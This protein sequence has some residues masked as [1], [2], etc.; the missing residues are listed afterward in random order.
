MYVIVSG[1]MEYPGRFSL[2]Q[3]VGSHNSKLQGKGRMGQVHFHKDFSDPP[4]KEGTKLS[5]PSPCNF[6]LQTSGWVGQ[7][8]VIGV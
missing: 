4:G 3:C 7:S 5:F 8:T 2:G 1:L 6:R